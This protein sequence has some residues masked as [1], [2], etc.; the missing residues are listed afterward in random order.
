MTRSVDISSTRQSDQGCPDRVCVIK[1]HEDGCSESHLAPCLATGAG[2]PMDVLREARK[3]GFREV[4]DG[5]IT[6]G[7]SSQYGLV[8]IC[9]V[10]VGSG[11]LHELC[12]QRGDESSWATEG[13][14]G[15]DDVDES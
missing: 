11:Y 10:E 3:D 8:F 9:A 1:T 6:V 14:F 2:V 4:F 15:R 12:K 13:S 5:E 7:C